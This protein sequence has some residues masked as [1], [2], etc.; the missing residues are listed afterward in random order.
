VGEAPKE[1]SSCPDAPHST[2]TPA[3]ALRVIQSASVLVRV[4]GCQD[5]LRDRGRHAAGRCADA[6]H[7]FLGAGQVRVAARGV[8]RPCACNAAGARC[9]RVVAETLLQPGHRAI[10]AWGACSS[11]VPRARAH[12]SQL[13]PSAL[14]ADSQPLSCAH[15]SGQLP[16]L[17]ACALRVPR[18]S[19][20]ETRK[21]QSRHLASA[22]GLAH[23]QP[24]RPQPFGPPTSDPSAQE[25]H[26]PGDADGRHA[27]KVVARTGGED[28]VG[29]LR[30]AGRRQRV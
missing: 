25:L 14:R 2:A 13:V 12:S 19:S 18:S 4:R 3:P 11:Q 8:R 15:A 21:S 30:G 24:L 27:A 23:P 5:E 9:G 22:R 26:H 6:V 20:A 17:Q 1:A 16:Q 29:P 28:D 10:R 7:P